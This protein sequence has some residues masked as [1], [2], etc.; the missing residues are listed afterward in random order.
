MPEKDFSNG[1]RTHE[2]SLRELT[3]DMDGKVDTIN[4]KI[5]N[6]HN[7]IDERD[8]LYSERNDSQKVAVD[9][10]LAAAKEQTGASFASSE[11]AIVKAENAQN[12]YNAR[13]NEFRATLADQAERLASKNELNTIN[14]N[15]EDKISRHDED[16]R[17]LREAQSKN[18]GKDETK[19]VGK[20]DNR[21]LIAIIISGLVALMGLAGLAI[22]ILTLVMK[23]RG[24]G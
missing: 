12:E 18:T 4:E 14:S 23:S 24:S 20:D 15:L 22:T 7:L 5:K 3:V 21:V 1:T 2:P 19:I 6:L 10:A 9:A 8:R 16:I 11:K 13:S 17:I